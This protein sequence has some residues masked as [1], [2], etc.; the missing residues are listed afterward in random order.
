MRCFWLKTRMGAGNFTFF[1]GEAKATLCLLMSLL[2][3]F[4]GIFDSYDNC[5]YAQ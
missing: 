1:P 3:A 4:C 2:I 5:I